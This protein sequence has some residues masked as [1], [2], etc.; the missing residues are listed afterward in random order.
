[1]YRLPIIFPVA[2]RRM[3]RVWSRAF[4]AALST[5]HPDEDIV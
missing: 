3:Y 4:D 2:L 1:L 5:S